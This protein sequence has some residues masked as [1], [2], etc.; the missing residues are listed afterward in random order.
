MKASVE[1]TFYTSKTGKWVFEMGTLVRRCGVPQRW[2]KRFE[3]LEN[4]E[5]SKEIT[6]QKSWSDAR[7]AFIHKMFTEHA[8]SIADHLLARAESA[9]TETWETPSPPD[10]VRIPLT[11]VLHAADFSATIKVGKGY[12]STNY[13]SQS[14]RSS[15]RIAVAMAADSIARMLDYY[16]QHPQERS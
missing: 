10:A 9:I 5:V 13:G 15:A 4:D 1:C 16:T 8:Y 7:S 11:L 12:R 2:F 3:T 6:K 14:L